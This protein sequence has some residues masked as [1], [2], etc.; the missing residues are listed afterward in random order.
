MFRFLTAYFLKIILIKLEFNFRI[1][2]LGKNIW[3][4]GSKTYY[5]HISQSEMRIMIRFVL[6]SKFANANECCRET[7]EKEKSVKKTSYV[8]VNA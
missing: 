7:R 3:L 8:S 6:G 5:S 1:K 4:Q 2:I